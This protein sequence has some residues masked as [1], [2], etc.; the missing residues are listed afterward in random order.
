M[1][2]A[3]LARRGIRFVQS[4]ISQ[5]D[6]SPN[7]TNVKTRGYHNLLRDRIIII[8]ILS[9]RV[10]RKILDYIY[11]NFIK[12]WQTRVLDILFFRGKAYSRN[13]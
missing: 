2:D 3:N 13:D 6:V 12:T 9:Y 1:A 7:E 4:R 8:L 11:R 5:R 10:K